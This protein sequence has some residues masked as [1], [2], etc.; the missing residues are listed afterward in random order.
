MLAVSALP[1]APDIADAF[2]TDFS[3]C[4]DTMDEQSAEVAD[5]RCGP[6]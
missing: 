1:L 6:E 4:L 3:G 2:F 5:K